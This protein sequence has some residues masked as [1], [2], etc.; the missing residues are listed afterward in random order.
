MARCPARTLFRPAVYH[1]YPHGESTSIRTRRLRQDTLEFRP[2]LRHPSLH[3]KNSVR[4]ANVPSSSG[5]PWWH[6][7]GSLCSGPLGHRAEQQWGSGDPWSP[8]RR[9]LV[10]QPGQS[11]FRPALRH[12]YPRAE[13]SVRS[14]PGHQSETLGGTACPP[15]VTCHLSPARGERCRSTLGHQDGDPV[16]AVSVQARPSSPVSARGAQPL[17]G[18][19]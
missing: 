18:Q 14:T 15:F 12:S 2:A 8:A 16:W 4:I 11:L 1:L 13:N 17:S 10:A 9:P 19:S 6:S 3:V 5:D 7:L